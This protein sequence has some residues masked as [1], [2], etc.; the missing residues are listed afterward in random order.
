MHDAS[1]WQRLLTNQTQEITCFE[2]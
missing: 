1:Y 2:T